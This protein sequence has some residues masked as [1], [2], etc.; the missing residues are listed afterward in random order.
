MHAARVER[1]ERLQRVLLLLADGK[2]RTTWEIISE[3][4]VCAV[5]SIISELRANG[6]EI[7]CRPKKGGKG[8]YEYR[9]LGG[10]KV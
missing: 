8:I 2:P 5:N 1:S 6:F 10:A 9:L 3:A 4:R 7:E